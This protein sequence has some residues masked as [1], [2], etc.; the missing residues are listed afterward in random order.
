MAW[1][2]KRYQVIFMVV[3]QKA[4]R[5]DMMHLKVV[6]VAAILAAPAVTR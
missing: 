1:G 3:T 5:L 6:H 4:A 2:T